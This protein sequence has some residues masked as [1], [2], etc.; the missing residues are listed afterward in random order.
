MFF[1]GGKTPQ[2]MTPEMRA[3]C[4]RLFKE[5]EALDCRYVAQQ[6]EGSDALGYIGGKSEGDWT[7]TV[8]RARAV[9][10]GARGEEIQDPDA[11]VIYDGGLRKGH[12]V[13]HMTA[14]VAERIWKKAHQQ[15]TGER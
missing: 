12:M 2:P 8:F 13:V 7:I 9:R 5:A 10:H 15:V 6:V 3:E 11:P 1:T 4:E 14:E